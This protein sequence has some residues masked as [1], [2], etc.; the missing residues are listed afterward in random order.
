MALHIARYLKQASFF[1]QISFPFFTN[2]FL[3][4]TESQI[5]TIAFIHVIFSFKLNFWIL[6]FLSFFWNTPI[7]FQN[8][9]YIFQSIFNRFC[10]L[11]LEEFQYLMA[12]CCLIST[13]TT[14][15]FSYFTQRSSFLTYFAKGFWSFEETLSN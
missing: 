11:L 7:F 2:G 13:E 10:H 5:K 14:I 9:I 15:F 8:I 6:S 4:E 1:L 3:L 12:I